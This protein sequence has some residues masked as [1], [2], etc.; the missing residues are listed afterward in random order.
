[1]SIIQID[2]KYL[3]CNKVD[4]NELMIG[5]Y[6]ITRLT[7]FKSKYWEKIEVSDPDPFY[8]AT[9]IGLD[10]FGGLGL[11]LEV[12]D[13]PGNDETECNLINVWDRSSIYDCSL[14][15]IIGEPKNSGLSFPWTIGGI[16]AFFIKIEELGNTYLDHYI[17]ELDDEH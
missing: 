2:T 4:S 13:E 14:D 17:K 16:E 1:M 11:F 5:A 10:K 8:I 7:T 12:V 9:E 3:D 15:E 6:F